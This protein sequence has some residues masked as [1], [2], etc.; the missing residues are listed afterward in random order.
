MAALTEYRQPGDPVDERTSALN[1]PRPHWLN[2]AHDDVL[3]LRAALDLIDAAHKLLADGKADKAALQALA[4]ANADA[5]EASEL[6]T[7][8][9]I[10]EMAEQLA[11]QDQQLSA[12]ITLLQADTARA[13]ATVVTLTAGRITAIRRTVAG[14]E[15]VTALT[16][17][18]AGRVATAAYPVPGG[19]RRTVTYSYAA[20][21]ALAGMTAVEAAEA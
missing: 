6:A 5:M 16:F 15:R 1:L 4:L 3:R 21:G 10:A 8:H 18:A 17:D 14:V 7:A 11:Q 2:D 9:E 13:T 12:A 20:G 19:K